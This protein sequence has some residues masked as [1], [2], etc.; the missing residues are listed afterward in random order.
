[1]QTI[2]IISN[3]INLQKNIFYMQQEKQKQVLANGSKKTSAL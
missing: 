3:E 2:N 1:M